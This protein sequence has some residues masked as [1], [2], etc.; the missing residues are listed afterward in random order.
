MAPAANCLTKTVRRAG[1]PW[2]PRWSRP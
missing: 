2:C 1:V